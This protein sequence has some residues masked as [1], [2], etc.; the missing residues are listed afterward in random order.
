MYFGSALQP[1]RPTALAPV[2]LAQPWAP[3]PVAAGDLHAFLTLVG[4]QG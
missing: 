4:G 2:C 3:F 1:V